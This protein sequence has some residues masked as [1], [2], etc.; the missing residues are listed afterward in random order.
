RRGTHL[1]IVTR[2]WERVA[3]HAT[4]IAEHV[5]FLLEGKIIRHQY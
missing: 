1:I 5:V 3:D 4:N 2:S